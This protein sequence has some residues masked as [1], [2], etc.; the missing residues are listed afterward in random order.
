ME[1]D[2]DITLCTCTLILSLSLNAK[3]IVLDLFANKNQKR[4]FGSHKIP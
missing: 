3:K 4:T 2:G 1:A